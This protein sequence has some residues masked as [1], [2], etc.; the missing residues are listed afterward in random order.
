MHAKFQVDPFKS[1]FV[2]PGKLK[3]GFSG[4]S[5][6]GGGVEDCLKRNISKLSR[7]CAKEH[8]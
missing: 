5:P 4:F 7:G 8:R 2:N 3:G 1:D 6:L